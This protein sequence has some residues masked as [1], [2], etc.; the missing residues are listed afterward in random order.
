MKSPSAVALTKSYKYSWSDSNVRKVPINIPVSKNSNSEPKS[1]YANKE[2]EYYMNNI[3]ANNNKAIKDAGVPVISTTP[4]VKKQPVAVKNKVKDNSL[5]AEKKAHLQAEYKKV[6]PTYGKNKAPVKEIA[7]TAVNA[8]EISVTNY[9]PDAANGALATG[10]AIVKSDEGSWGRVSQWQKPA[11]E[12]AVEASEAPRAFLGTVTAVAGGVAGEVSAT[13]KIAAAAG[14][15]EKKATIIENN[16]SRDND[17]LSTDLNRATFKW[18]ETEIR[19]PDVLSGILKRNDVT[20]KE[21]VNTS[22]IFENV[23]NQPVG[24]RANPS[25]YLNQNYIN[26]QLSL[27]EEGGTKF[28][29]SKNYEKYGLGQ[30]DG[31]SFILPSKQADKLVEATNNDPVKLA[32]ALGIPRDMLQNNS[33]LRIDIPNPNQNGL[34]LPSG[35]EA[36]A[37]PM[38]IP[39]GKLPNGNSEAIID[40]GKLSS[41]KYIVTPIK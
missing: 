39:G 3:A 24:Y 36:G 37:N 12:I 17:I 4:I 9:I 5:S 6:N 40:V 2:T 15:A 10:E 34:R 30:T 31:T 33:L 11:N 7:K 32:D 27:F 13:S 18:S 41:D 21:G 38:W 35:N 29:V 26:N 23:L 19:N 25:T 22:H 28:M 14:K 16:I 1:I 8:L 20:L